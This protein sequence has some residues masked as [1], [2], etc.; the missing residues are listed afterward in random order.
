MR[1][2]EEAGCTTGREENPA[3][4]TGPGAAREAHSKGTVSHA[5]LTG[6]GGGGKVPATNVP[7]EEP[8]NPL[9]EEPAFRTDGSAR[10]TG[11]RSVVTFGGVEKPTGKKVK[12][13][14][15]V[16]GN[17]RLPHQ[18]DTWTEEVRERPRSSVGSGS[19]PCGRR[20]GSAGQTGSRSPGDNSARE[21][22]AEA[23]TN[24]V[25]GTGVSARSSTPRKKS[26][27]K[28]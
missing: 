10:T 21:S 6:E 20:K 19:R 2:S 13:C 23:A 15:G 25:A 5:Y 9:L 3:T 8:V 14:S 27:E 7:G 4:T 26:L 16:G 28:A 1:E 24:V 18:R 12:V 11:E 17:N 22:V